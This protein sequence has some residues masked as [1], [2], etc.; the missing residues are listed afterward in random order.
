MEHMPKTTQQKL[1]RQATTF[2][3]CGGKAVVALIRM[4]LLSVAVVFEGIGKTFAALEGL[5][6]EDAFEAER[7]Q[8]SSPVRAITFK[9]LPKG[10][11]GGL[12]GAYAYSPAPALTG[13]AVG[14]G[15]RA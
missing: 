4:L 7:A 2:L 3:N 10:E 14:R 13:K 1:A 15:H 12:E 6:K 11:R 8:K 5:I 9:A